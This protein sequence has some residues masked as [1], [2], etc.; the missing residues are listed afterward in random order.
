[1]K[2]IFVHS[3]ATADITGACPSRAAVWGL[4]PESAGAAARPSAVAY[5]QAAAGSPSAKRL[6]KH[7]MTRINAIGWPLGPQDRTSG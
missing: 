1:M 5:L 7:G 3:E 2:T 6:A 4:R